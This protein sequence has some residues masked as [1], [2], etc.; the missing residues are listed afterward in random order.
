MMELKMNNTEKVVAGGGISLAGLVATAL[1]MHADVAVLKTQVERN[2]YLLNNQSTQTMTLTKEIVQTQQD[3]T[4]LLNQMDR[5]LVL[6][7]K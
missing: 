5:R 3:L 4:K 2:Q 6:L 1:T 7:E